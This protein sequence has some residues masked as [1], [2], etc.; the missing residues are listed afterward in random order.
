MIEK[1]EFLFRQPSFPEE[2]VTDKYYLAVA[3]RLLKIMSSSLFGKNIPDA[4]LKRTAIGITSYYQDIISD[5]GIW[6]SFVDA[7]RSLYGYS[8]PFWEDGPDYIEYELNV[9]DVRF[10][11]WY[12]VAMLD[13]DRRFLDPHDSKL[14]EMSDKV[15]DFLAAEYEEAPMPDNYSIAKDL[16]FYDPED[17]EKIYH[18]GSWLF[19]HCY[20]MTP[21]F[22]LT[23]SEIM[24]DKE[25]IASKDVVKLQERMEKSMLEDPTGPLALFIPEWLKLII[26]GQMPETTAIPTASVS[27]ENGET[28]KEVH[29]FYESF[30]KGTGGNIVQYFKD[31]QEL[32]NFLITKLGWEA[33]EEHLSVL[34]DEKWMALMV[35]PERG[36]LVARDV[37]RC[38]ADPLNPYYDKDYATKHSFE[39]LALRGR[40]PAD[41]MKYACGNGYLPDAHFPKSDDHRLVQTNWDFI[42]RCYLQQYYRD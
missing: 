31:Y 3:N 9:E 27:V 30:V 8:T 13:E 11:S 33:K 35:N 4:I 39:L 28:Q 17:T 12:F 32:N 41:M 42:M 22:A 1:K 14:V 10:L 18:L 24:S 40:C 36:M 20:L 21:A 23:L 16:D 19:L 7:N 5:A 2:E 38:I 29:P 25:L 34:K 15:Y 26:S 6:R 37:A